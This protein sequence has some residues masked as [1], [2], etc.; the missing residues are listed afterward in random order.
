MGIVRKWRIKLKRSLIEIYN[1]YIK[2][3]I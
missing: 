3:V 2:E 1:T